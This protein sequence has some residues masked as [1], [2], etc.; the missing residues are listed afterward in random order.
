MPYPTTQVRAVVTYDKA[1]VLKSRRDSEN[2]GIIAPMLRVGN[3]PH[4]FILHT[5]FC[6]PWISRNIVLSFAMHPQ[7][8]SAHDQLP[9][10]LCALE[11][12]GQSQ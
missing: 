10:E 8:I 7:A 3:D 2:Q 1:V 12:R 4:R 11:V 9:F 6:L 5:F